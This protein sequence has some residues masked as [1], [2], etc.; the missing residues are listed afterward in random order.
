MTMLV[1]AIDENGMPRLHR[2]NDE[3]CEVCK[4]DRCLPGY[5]HPRR[6]VYYVDAERFL[7]WNQIEAQNGG[8]GKSVELS[9]ASL[10]RKVLNEHEAKVRERQEA[11]RRR[12][13]ER[14][15]RY[16]QRKRKREVLNPEKCHLKGP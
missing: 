2:L 16:Y 6:M 7:N 4:L 1:D 9:V 12:D 5:L 8:R 3:P 15:R 10:S 11:R 14:A 13:R